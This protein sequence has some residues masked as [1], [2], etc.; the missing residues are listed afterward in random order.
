MNTGRKPVSIRECIRCDNTY[1]VVGETAI[2][3][4]Q[5]RP[6]HLDPHTGYIKTGI[7][8]DHRRNESG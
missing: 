8:P 7:C 4:S 6:A 1:M 5:H 2:R 3:L